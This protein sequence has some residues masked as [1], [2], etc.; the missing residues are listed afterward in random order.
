MFPVAS[1]F[2]GCLLGSALGDAVGEL[3]FCFRTK[4]R[5]DSEIERCEL[6][7]Y[8]DDTAMA[9]GVARSLAEKKTIDPEHLGRIFHENFNKEPWRGY[10][11][12]PP[13]IFSRV[14]STGR[15][16]VEVAA[17]LFGGRGSYGNGSAMRVAPVGLFFHDSAELRQQASRSALPTHS[18]E[19]ARDGAAL[20][21]TAVALALRA[22]PHGSFPRDRFLEGLFEAARTPAFQGKIR[23]VRELVFSDAQDRHAAEALGKTVAVHESLPFAMYCFAKYPQSFE[24]CIYCSI[25]NG[26]DR[27]T[28]GAM[29]GAISGARLGVEGL[30][31]A[32]LEKL[33]GRNLLETLAGSLL[34]G[35]AARGRDRTQGDTR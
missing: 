21:A 34:R 28:L 31:K 29:A 9:M 3:A 5:L 30:P 32:W 20:Q 22:E 23:L 8:T 16:Y 15:S 4:K 1:K 12:G 27:D 13:S 24:D 6:L 19:L 11:A 10:A 18:H 2:S 7:R 26:G 25:L 35:R 14:E 33:E 17:G